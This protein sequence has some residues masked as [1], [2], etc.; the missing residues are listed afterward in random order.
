MTKAA[1]DEDLPAVF[2]DAMPSNND[3]ADL[4][5]IN[6]LIDEQTPAERAE[7]HKV[8]R[9]A[10][11]GGVGTRRQRTEQCNCMQN[12]GNEALKTGLKHRKKFYFRE[13]S[14]A[15]TKGLEEHCGKDDIDAVLF[16]NRAQVNLVLG[17]NRNA[18]EDGLAAMKLDNTNL[19]V[20][21]HCL[22]SLPASAAASCC[23]SSFDL[24]ITQYPA[25]FDTGDLPSGQSCIQPETIQ[26]SYCTGYTRT[27]PRYRRS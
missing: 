14:I 7:S 3:N 22:T 25:A 24:N 12:Q 10:R 17:N 18:L 19:K 15:Y 2:W 1:N 23:S 11:H 26:H 6:A 8:S 27:Q 21:S 5:A 16:S 9:N 4:A 13:A 20:R